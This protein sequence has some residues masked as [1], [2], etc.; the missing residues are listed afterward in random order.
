MKKRAPIWQVCRIPNHNRELRSYNPRVSFNQHILEHVSHVFRP[1]LNSLRV[2]RAFFA[3]VKYFKEYKKAG[4]VLFHLFGAPWPSNL[5]RFAMI[6]VVQGLFL[7]V[8][9]PV[10]GLGN[11]AFCWT[12]RVSQIWASLFLRNL[13]WHSCTLDGFNG[14]TAQSW[15]ETTK[16]KAERKDSSGWLVVSKMLNFHRAYGGFHVD[17]KNNLVEISNK[18]I[19]QSEMVSWFLFKSTKMIIFVKPCHDIHHLPKRKLQP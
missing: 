8:H 14:Q 13:R 19:S 1:G 18:Y 12:N 6:W 3:A 9:R 15:T 2:F 7:W 17:Q 5:L 4:M 10:W 16:R 11:L